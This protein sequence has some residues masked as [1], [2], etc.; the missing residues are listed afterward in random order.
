MD[1]TI[2]Y[3]GKYEYYGKIAA[4][5]DDLFN[6]IPARLSVLLMLVVAIFIPGCNLKN[7]W[8][9]FWRDRYQT[10]SPNA[11]QTMALGA[12]LLKVKLTKRNCYSLGDAL[13]TISANDLSR[14]RLLL[15]GGSLLMLILTA[16]VLWLIY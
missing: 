13:K 5:L 6:L 7:G 15:R 1:A 10:E 8:K 16:G 11:G 3:H 2:G 12:G 14:A 9:I 4:R